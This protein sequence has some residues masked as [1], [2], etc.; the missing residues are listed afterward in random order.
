M[1]TKVRKNQLLIIMKVIGEELQGNIVLF[2]CRRNSAAPFAGDGKVRQVF[3]ADFKT[4]SHADRMARFAENGRQDAQLRRRQT[5]FLA[6]SGVVFAFCDSVFA[7]SEN[8]LAFVR[9]S[10]L[11][12][13][14]SSLGVRKSSLFVRTSSL[15][16]R[17]SSLL[18]TAPPLL[19]TKWQFPV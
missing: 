3:E 13:K 14:T 19:A 1:G 4:F 6:P 5:S 9:K 12:V 10:S 11:R 7:P 16:A 8:G 17:I 18:L 2:A 15:G